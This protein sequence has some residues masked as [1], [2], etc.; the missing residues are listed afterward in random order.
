MS[1]LRTALMAFDGV[2]TAP[3]VAAK[4]VAR[5]D[6]DGLVALCDD[7]DCAVAA[8]WVVKALAEEGVAVDLRGVIAT[9]GRQTH[10][11]AQLHVL[12]S[13]RFAPDAVENVED[14][15]DLLNAKK[16]LVRV[17]ALDAFVRV[18]DLRADLREE[19][20]AL[21]SAALAGKAASLRARARDLKVICAGW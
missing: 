11:A 18:A 19:A 20:R 13:V 2:H 9:L 14:I 7:A 15:R 3:L 16:A 1:R 8:T 4:D 6:L 17:W 21:V 12:Q 10:W 5:A